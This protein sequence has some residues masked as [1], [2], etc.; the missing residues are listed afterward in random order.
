MPNQPDPDKSRIV[1]SEWADVRDELTKIREEIAKEE[2]LSELT[3]AEFMRRLT[4]EY[5]NKRRKSRGK[6]ALGL[7][8]TSLPGGAS[9]HTISRKS[10]AG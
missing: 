1:Y 2:G 3:E 9:P 8:P 4:L 5:V 6:K 10:R 7:D